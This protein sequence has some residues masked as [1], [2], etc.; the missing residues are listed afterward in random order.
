ML[1]NT[2][3]RTKMVAE[4]R[5][6]DLI[7]NLNNA[8][9]KI[10][11]DF[12]KFVIEE[13]IENS[14]KFSPKGKPIEISSGIYDG[15]V[16]IKFT[17]HGRGMTEEEINSIGPFVQHNREYYEQPGNGLGLVIVKKLVDLYGGTM[18]IDSVKES[19]TSVILTFDLAV[20]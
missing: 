1:I 11:I 20:N 17:D 10:E 15:K 6:N 4:N 18:Y 7:I 14:V 5:I 13:I 3:A 19:Y 9:I 12:F 16:N 8:C 2:I